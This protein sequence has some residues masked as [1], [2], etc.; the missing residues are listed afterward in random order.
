[1]LRSSTE[2]QYT[3]SILGHQSN[4]DWEENAEIL[5]RYTG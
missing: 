1:M 3:A 4:A 2:W 5:R